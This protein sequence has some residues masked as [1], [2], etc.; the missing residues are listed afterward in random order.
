M[1]LCR[2]QSAIRGNALEKSGIDP[3]IAFILRALGGDSYELC[4]NCLHLRTHSRP[5]SRIERS[6]N[7]IYGG[8]LMELAAANHGLITHSDCMNEHAF[9]QTNPGPEECPE[10]L[11]ARTCE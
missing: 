6:E 7:R 3:L 2:L 9:G 11:H 8:S 5:T 4:R 10:T 1:E